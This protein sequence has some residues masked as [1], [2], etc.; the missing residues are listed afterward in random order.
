MDDSLRI[1]MKKGKE[2]KRKWKRDLIFCQ[3][4]DVN[5]ISSGKENKADR[6]WE[7]DRKG[8]DLR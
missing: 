6:A 7:L 2:R 8:L 5:A 4:D 3:K 1:F